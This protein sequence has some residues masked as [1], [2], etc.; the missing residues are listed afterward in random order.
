MKASRQ[1]ESFTL[2]IR[3]LTPFLVT[4]GRKLQPFDY[5]LAHQ[6]RT[7]TPLIRVID[8]ERLIEDE[9]IPL[10]KKMEV[11]ERRGSWNLDRYYRY[12]LLCAFKRIEERAELLECLRDAG[13]SPILPASSIKGTIRTALAF[14][15][16][17]DRRDL[18]QSEFGRMRDRR[19]RPGLGLERRLFGESL[20]ENALRCIRV[21]EP[22]CGH[23]ADIRAY[24][25]GLMTSGRTGFHRKYSFYAEAWDAAMKDPISASVSLELFPNVNRAGGKE[26][27]PLATKEKLLGA[28]K[29]FSNA[30][31]ESEKR[32]YAAFSPRELEGRWSQLVH[33]AEGRIL[34]PLGFGSGWHARTLGLLFNKDDLA[35]R[36][37]PFL[38]PDRQ[39]MEKGGAVFYPKSRRW[40]LSAGWPEA[41]LG[42]TLWSIA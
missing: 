3:P 22:P 9:K 14:S 31:I 4:S 16:L 10:E 7:G 18:L 11:V 8:F 34:L 30:L 28:L 41:P 5:V 1:V 24:E 2:Q 42:W 40:I 6:P 26:S 29:S 20:G 35:R 12:T 21:A 25:V 33:R 13:G 38:S 15:L 19:E 36:L 39:Y 37:K 32:F 17:K 23:N 27:E